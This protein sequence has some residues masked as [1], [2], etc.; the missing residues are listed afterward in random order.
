MILNAVSFFIAEGEFKLLGKS[1]GIL[2]SFY[3]NEDNFFEKTMLLFI[4][5]IFNHILGM[6][7]WESTD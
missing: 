1:M 5:G 2:K 3:L 6:K 7:I 4:E